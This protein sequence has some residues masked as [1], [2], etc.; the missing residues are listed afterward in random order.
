MGRYYRTKVKQTNRNQQVKTTAINFQGQKIRFKGN[1]CEG[2]KR[3]CEVSRGIYNASL[4]P[5]F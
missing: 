4:M 5:A 3:K 1:T 2:R